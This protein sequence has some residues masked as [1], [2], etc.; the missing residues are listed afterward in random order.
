[1]TT[2]TGTEPLPDTIAAPPEPLRRFSW[3]IQSMVE[4]ADDPREIL[5]IGRDLMGRLVAQYDWLPEV[6]ARLDGAPFR[7]YQLYADQM[8]RFTVIATVLAPGAALPVCEQKVWE[9]AG[10]LRGEIV[11]QRLALP[12]GAAPVAR[13]AEKR[14]GAGAVD[15]FAPKDGDGLAIA[16]G[17]ATAPAIL[18]Q[19]HGAEIGGEARR[20]VGPD[21]GIGSFTTVYANPPEV[22]AWDILTIQAR[23][24]D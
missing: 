1:M 24:T 5:M 13:V 23:I 8:T 10:V 2:E 14:L 9:L 4:L 17:S 18:I 7:Q 11:R 16:N 19:V 20:T 3:D 6:F 22:P 21:G 12:D 15:A